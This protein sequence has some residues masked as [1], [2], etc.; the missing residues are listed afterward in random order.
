MRSTATQVR[1]EGLRHGLGRTIS[2]VPQK[3]ERSNKDTTQAK[4]ALACLEAIEVPEQNLS[5]LRLREGLNGFDLASHQVA[6]L[7]LAGIVRFSIDQHHACTALFLPASVPGALESEFIA[8]VLSQDAAIV[9]VNPDGLVIDFK[10][11][12]HSDAIAPMRLIEKTC[13]TIIS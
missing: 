6:N 11:M 4:T 10:Y 8:Q 13:S 3:M 5:L 2:A 9:R 7:S 1:L 12:V